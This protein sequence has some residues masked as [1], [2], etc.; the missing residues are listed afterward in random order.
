MR[1]R[2]DAV[3]VDLFLVQIDVGDAELHHAGAGAGDGLFADDAGVDE[4]LA[5]AHATPLLLLGQG[6]LDLLGGGQPGVD[7][8]LAEAEAP[9]PL[10]DLVGLHRHGGLD[11]FLLEDVLLDEDLA[12]GPG[13]FG[14]LRLGAVFDVVLTDE[15]LADEQF[16]QRGRVLDGGDALAEEEDSLV[17]RGAGDG[18]PAEA[19][20]VVQVGGLHGDGEL[21]P[22]RRV[23]LCLLPPFQV[24]LG[25]LGDAVDGDVRDRAHGHGDADLRQAPVR[26]WSSSPSASRIRRFTVL[27]PD[28][29]RIPDIAG[30]GVAVVDLLTV[31]HGLEDDVVGPPADLWGYDFEGGAA[32]DHGC[33]EQKG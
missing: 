13:A 23:D 20:G 31:A 30:L 19:E 29:G 28:T 5:Q 32:R 6:Q 4:D 24:G 17:Q 16:A 14:D 26:G 12:D 2:L 8:D 18:E 7:E 11:G 1:H 10:A 33:G 3:G 21:A 9:A 27:D 22:V 15:A 25:A